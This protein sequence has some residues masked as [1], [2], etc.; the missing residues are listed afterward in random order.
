MEHKRAD[1]VQSLEELKAVLGFSKSL[2]I[3]DTKSLK[4]DYVPPKY[5]MKKYSI[6]RATVARRIERM[7]GLGDKYKDSFIRLNHQTLL[8]KLSDF[9]D[10]MTNYGVYEMNEPTKGGNVCN[11]SNNSK[12]Y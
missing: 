4:P 3:C 1:K 8:I 5:I 9:H 6:S 11:Q 2:M 7:R 12:G 10:Y